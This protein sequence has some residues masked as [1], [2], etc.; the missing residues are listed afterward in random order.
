LIF[1]RWLFFRQ[2]AVCVS[3]KARDMAGYRQLYRRTFATLGRR[4][5]PD[6]AVSDNELLAAE[7][8]LGIRIPQSVA[9]FYRLAGR[10]R[11]YTSV[12]NRI[13]PPAELRVEAGKLVFLEENQ[14]VVLWRTD[15]GAEPSDDP[16]AYQATNDEP[17]VWDAVNDRCS[18]FLLVMLH[19]E[20]AF[21][22]AMPNAATALV[23]E[24]LVKVVDRKL[25]FVGEVNGMRAYNQPGAAVCFVKWE[26]GWRIFA[27]SISDAGMNKLASELHVTWETPDL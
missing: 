5:S 4:L 19:W 27:G 20:A 7:R 3:P 12:F 8:R 14:A 24:I 26:D 15:A 21:G 16:S 18:V 2:M 22:G 10:A 11:D 9:D 25:S 13:I 1:E 17:L 6:D 23:D